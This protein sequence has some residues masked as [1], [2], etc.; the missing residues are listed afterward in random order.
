MTISEKTSVSVGLLALIVGGMGW[1]TNI[2]STGIQNAEAITKIQDKQDTVAET[3]SD[4]RVRLGVI[5][6]NQQAEKKSLDTLHEKLSA[7]QDGL[8]SQAVR[9]RHENND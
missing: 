8:E 5:E 7:M 6:N 2:N 3:L 9:S 1:L 4:I